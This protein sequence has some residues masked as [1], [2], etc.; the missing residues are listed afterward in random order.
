MFRNVEVQIERLLGEGVYYF[1]YDAL[2]DTFTQDEVFTTDAGAEGVVLYDDGSANMVVA[3]G[4]VGAGNAGELKDGDTLTG[5]TSGATAAINGA[6]TKGAVFPN[7]AT[8][9]SRPIDFRKATGLAAMLVTAGGSS[10]LTMELL[11]S[12][13]RDGTYMSSDTAVTIMSAVSPGNHWDS[14]TF[15]TVPWAKVKGTVGGA[16]ITITNDWLFSG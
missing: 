7:G 16:T 3:V 2:T 8:F 5:A 4:S 12:W 13:K 9:F 11:G 6:V 10:T 15:P 14:S 1:A